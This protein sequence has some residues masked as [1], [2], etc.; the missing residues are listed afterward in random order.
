[1]ANYP[2]YDLT[3]M[4]PAATYESLVQYNAESAS[5]VSGVGGGDL[6]QLN[7]TASISISSSY[8]PTIGLTTI[9]YLTESNKV[10][11]SFVNGL[12]HSVS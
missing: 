3:G 10:T 9:I 1:M 11:M 12:L 8:A 2:K 7:I 6:P 4:T 5:L